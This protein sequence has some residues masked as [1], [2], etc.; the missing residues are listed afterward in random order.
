MKIAKVVIFAFAKRLHIAT[1]RNG[2]RRANA[3]T[4][5]GTGAV[6]PDGAIYLDNSKSIGGS[7]RLEPAACAVT[8]K[9]SPVTN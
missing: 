2:P 6:A 4:W 1:I 8:A 7:G 3:A 5:V 9:S